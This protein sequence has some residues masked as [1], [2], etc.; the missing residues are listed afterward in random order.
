MASAVSVDLSGW[1]ARLLARPYLVI[2]AV[3]VMAHLVL[4]ALRMRGDYFQTDDFY[5]FWI[6]RDHGRR[7]QT[8]FEPV[9]GQVVPLFRLTNLVFFNLAG[10]NHLAALW[11][12]M[13]MT[14]GSV[15]LLAMIAARARAPLWLSAGCVMIAAISWVPAQTLWWWSSAVHVVFGTFFALCAVYIAAYPERR[16]DRR[17]VAALALVGL[18][19]LCFYTKTVFALVLC[20]VIRI[21]VRRGHSGAALWRDIL[22]ALGDLSG[23]LGVLLAY[24]AMF[25][26][27]HTHEAIALGSAQGT[28]LAVRI[29]L[30]YGLLGDLVGVRAGMAHASANRLAEL[31]GDLTAV[32]VLTAAISQNRRSLWLW[33]GLLACAAGGYSLIAATRA[34]LYGYWIAVEPRYNVDIMYEALAV[35]IIAFGAAYGAAPTGRARRLTPVAGLGLFAVIGVLQISGAWTYPAGFPTRPVKAFMRQLDHDAAALARDGGGLVAQRHVPTWIVGPFPLAVDAL[36]QFSIILRTPFQVGPWTTATY[37]LD[38][39]G[40]LHSFASL[41]RLQLTDVDGR[42]MTMA[43]VAPFEGVGQ[44][45]SLSTRSVEGRADPEIAPGRSEV[46]ITDGARVIAHAQRP[47]PDRQ[48]SESAMA[49]FQAELP[50]PIPPERLRAY[51]VVDRRLAIALPIGKDAIANPPSGDFAVDPRSAGAALNMNAPVISGDWAADG[52]YRPDIGLPPLSGPGF[53]SYAGK[54]DAGVGR[55]SWA[56]SLPGGGRTVG[57]PL[58]TGPA[59]EGLSVRVVNALSGSEIARLV[60]P[61]GLGQWRVWRVGLPAGVKAIRIEA[62]DKG[63]GFGEWV[64]V[65][66]PHLIDKDK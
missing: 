12:R 39:Q 40:R 3:A 31:L 17:R 30:Q 33:L 51:L 11:L 41:P 55:L 7:W 19:G 56:G 35:I 64:A 61:R 5:N 65:G 26:I 45:D 59:G 14:A 50:A 43:L 21:Y 58:V 37:Q 22:G 13:A 44:V 9:A 54:G 36:S 48:G 8:L 52:W 25:E 32:A 47:S 38:D 46:V 28:G 18:V 53:G 16:L 1:R 24:V 42:V 15:A 2:G 27:V 60:N 66:T 57:I 4:M 63:A 49:G 62:E 23:V 20:G 29:A 6:V 10:L 34:Q